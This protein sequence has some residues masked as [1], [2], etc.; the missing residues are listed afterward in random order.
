[1]IKEFNDQE[2]L[3]E[4]ASKN[5]REFDKLYRTHYKRLFVISFKYTHHQE[6]S[7]EVV[8]DVFMKIWDQSSTLIINQSLSAYLS[9]AVVN[10]SL[11]ALKK[12]KRSKELA[13]NYQ[14]DDIIFTDE[15]AD[16]TYFIERK[17]ILLEE[18]IEKLPPQCKKILFMSKYHK[19]KQ[20]E[21]AAQLNISI[22]TVK[23]HLTY[24]YKKLREMGSSKEMLIIIMIVYI[25]LLSL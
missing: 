15:D 14:A 6:V 7:E 5:Y 16:D 1:M 4:I 20:Q 3:K 21:I 2:V 19:L 8:H 23:N 24:A 12:I 10:T 22:K 11:N 25:G 17:L 13:E 18:S 9:K